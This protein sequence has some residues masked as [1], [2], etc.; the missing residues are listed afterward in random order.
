MPHVI[1]LPT[2]TSMD[3]GDYLIMEE[4]SGGTKKITRKN[5]LSHI[6]STIDA[7]NSNV[8]TVPTNTVTNCLS[9]SI[10]TTGTYIIVANVRISARTNSSFEASISTVETSIQNT[11]FGGY[12]QLASTTNTSS[13]GFNLTRAFTITQTSTLPYNVYLNVWQGSGANQTIAA[14]TANLRAVKIA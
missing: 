14:K 7:Q 2:A 10:P 11:V 3:D 4:S 6:G 12:M 5:A 13:L 9:I 1:N 8:I